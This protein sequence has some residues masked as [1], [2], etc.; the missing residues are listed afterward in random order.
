MKIVLISM[1]DATSLFIHQDAVHL[2]NLGIASIGANID[3]GHDVYIIDL[4][5][6]RNSIRKYLTKTLTRIQ[7]D[8]VGLSCMSFQYNTCIR[9]IRLIKQLLPN[10]KIVIGGYHP[11]MMY[12]TIARSSEAEL[13][14]FIVVGE[15][16]ECFRRLVNALDHKDCFDNIPSLGYKRDGRF[17]FNPIGELLDLAKIKPPIRDKRRLTSGYHFMASK[18]EAVETS[19]GCT[20]SCNFCS[21]RHM[22]GRT[23]RTFPI[24]RVIADLDYIYYNN[25]TRAVFIIDDNMVLDPQR[26]K[27]LCDA[28]IQRNYKNFFL[29]VQAD[30]ITVSKN[31]D[32]IAK[33]AKAGFRAIFLGMENVSAKNLE[34]LKKGNILDATKKAVALCHK[35]GILVIGGVIFGLP[36]DDEQS[37]IDNYQY[38]KQLKIDGPYCQMLTPYPKTPIRQDLIERGLV[39]NFNDYRWYD[40]SWANIKTNYLESEQLQ[41]FFWLYRQKILG[42]WEPTP[43][44]KKLWKLWTSSWKYCIRP[45]MK[46]FYNRRFRKLGWEGLYKEHIQ[47]LRKINHFEDL[48]DY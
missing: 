16:E 6:K 11:S 1:P 30:C 39:T 24:E 32:M 25:N 45:V 3:Q 42:W 4:I 12:E 5:R 2:P 9:V 40:G 31:E 41:Y 47:N 21:M 15:G 20:R 7:P 36:D 46:Y 29:S 35:Y 44:Q 38:V 18:M 23:Y 48:K 8:V 27:L 14:D 43:I 13:I 34:T 37:I 17:V 33:M 19:R 10:V 28:I 22:Y 26:V